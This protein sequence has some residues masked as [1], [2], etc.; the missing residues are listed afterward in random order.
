VAAASV[1]DPDDPDAVEEDPRI[2]KLEQ[3]LAAI[4]GN[5]EQTVLAQQQ[6]LQE[7]QYNQALEQETAS[8]DSAVQAIKAKGADELAVR[9]VLG[10]A[11]LHFM[12]TGKPADIEQLYDEWTSS[13]RSAILSQPRPVDGAP[14][15]PSSSGGAPVAGGT[16]LA[17]ASRSETV[18]TFAAMLAANKGN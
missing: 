16:N 10:K 8:I 2:A 6:W 11:Q 13:V 5:Q 9:E 18:D 12:N 1:A 7:Q 3:E 17:E 14:R 15:L 4:R